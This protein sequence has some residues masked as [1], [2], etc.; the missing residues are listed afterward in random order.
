MGVA[1]PVGVAIGIGVA[2]SVGLGLAVGVGV[3][4][5]GAQPT[6]SDTL[7]AAMKGHLE[8]LCTGRSYRNKRGGARN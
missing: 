1:V 8:F 3:D 2:D 4:S 6:S 7:K 5:G